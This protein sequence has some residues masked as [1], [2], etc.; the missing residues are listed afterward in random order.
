MV[1]LRETGTAGEDALPHGRGQGNGVQ[2]RTV[3][4]YRAA[5]AEDIDK[6]LDY[7]ANSSL[8]LGRAKARAVKAEKM[9][10]HIEALMALAST[11]KSA[12]ARKWAARA[13]EKYTA[14]IDEHA[15]AEGELSKLYGLRQAAQAKVDAWRTEAASLRGNRL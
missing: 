13:T 5:G 4:T 12:D 8:E 15:E 1:T 2:A 11:E 14:A 6:A 9:I 3:R 7:L 10:G